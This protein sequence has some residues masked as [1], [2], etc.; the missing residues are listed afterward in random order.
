M[1]GRALNTAQ[2]LAISAVRSSRT[3]H[4]TFDSVTTTIYLMVC[5][6][7]VVW[8]PPGV[9]DKAWHKLLDLFGDLEVAWQDLERRQQF[10]EL[11]FKWVGLSC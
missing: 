7:C 10:L 5:C 4:D 2:G 11:P 8:V 3:A 1:S 9:S 6:L